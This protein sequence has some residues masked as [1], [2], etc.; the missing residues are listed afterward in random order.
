MQCVQSTRQ[1]NRATVTEKTLKSLKI[2]VAFRT[3][4]LL[5][6][7]NNAGLAA[8]W[9]CR[10]RPMG[11]A[12]PAVHPPSIERFAPVIWDAASEQRKTASAA[13]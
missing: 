5:R 13:T 6:S 7:A 9:P 12:H 10:I 11:M 3:A 1:F 8:R 2:T 4:R